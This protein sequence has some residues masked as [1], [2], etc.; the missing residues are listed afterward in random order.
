MLSVVFCVADTWH[1]V[2]VQGDRV[3][4]LDLRDNDVVGALPGELG[5]LTELVTL[6]L[7]LNSGITSTSSCSS[8]CSLVHHHAVLLLTRA[9][10]QLFPTSPSS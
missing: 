1:G 10:L 9:G 3:V 5:E 8:S 6:L 4:E 2:T 7:A